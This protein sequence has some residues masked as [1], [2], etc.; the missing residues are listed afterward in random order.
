MSKKFHDKDS[1]EWEATRKFMTG[2]SATSDDDI[3]KK[4]GDK[5]LKSLKSHY[6]VASTDKANIVFNK[7][8]IAASYTNDNQD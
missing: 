3:K 8:A 2:P 1:P 5:Y 6:K 4:Y 7:L